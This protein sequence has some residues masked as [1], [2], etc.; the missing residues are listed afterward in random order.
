MQI[1]IEDEDLWPSGTLMANRFLIVNIILSKRKKTVPF[2]TH[3]IPAPTGPKFVNHGNKIEGR[4]T[5]LDTAV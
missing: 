2:P 5:L 4:C 3:P 1:Y